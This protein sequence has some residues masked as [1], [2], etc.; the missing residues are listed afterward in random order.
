[1][2]ILGTDLKRK[3]N[4]LIDERKVHCEGA[5][6]FG[7]LDDNFKID[8][9]KC[10]KKYV[11]IKNGNQ[12]FYLVKG[13][14]GLLRTNPISITE[15][16]VDINLTCDIPDAL[17]VYSFMALD[18]G[19]R[20]LFTPELEE[21]APNG[22]IKVIKCLLRRYHCVSLVDKTDGIIDTEEIVKSFLFNVSYLR[23]RNFTLVKKDEV[24]G[25]S[26]L[27]LRI[28]S[29]VTDAP[30]LKYSE[31][32]VSY[33]LAGNS[34]RVEKIKFLSFY[35]VL[36]YQFDKLSK[37]RVGAE[38]KTIVTDPTFKKSDLKC[39]R[40]LYET[41]IKNAKKNEY[42]LLSKLI[43]EVVSAEELREF[44]NSNT[45][46]TVSSAYKINDTKIDLSNNND[47]VIYKRVTK[48]VYG[49][50]NA[51]VHSKESEESR[52]MPGDEQKYKGEINLV[53]FLAEKTIIHFGEVMDY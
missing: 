27:E 20:W 1:M 25:E 13:L 26:A 35:N 42:D 21:T 30:L 33:Y 19:R 10:H 53:K 18:F 5:I 52:Y 24:V 16:S 23:G 39:Y 9:E 43:K 46:Y 48:R 49:V 41:S 34:A 3:L 38:L 4:E 17:A 15:P 31:D 36:E 7:A 6:N 8:F 2:E 50:R 37:D 28:R 40:K 12:C 44:F 14:D 29:S 22:L 45:S 47:D 11:A 51:L 32:L